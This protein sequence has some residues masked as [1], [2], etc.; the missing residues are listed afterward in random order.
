MIGGKSRVQ[1]TRKSILADCHP[2]VLDRVIWEEQFCS[3]DRGL[4]MCLRVLHQLVKPDITRQGIGVQKDQIVGARHACAVVTGSCKPL[5][6][7]VGNY[8]D[9]IAV[10]SKQTSGELVRAIVH[11]HNVRIHRQL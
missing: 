11:R 3:D 10:S 6:G 5:I 4:W 9:P 8:L 7:G 2:C 1:V